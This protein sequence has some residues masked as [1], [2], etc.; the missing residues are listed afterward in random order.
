MSTDIVE[1]KKK[2][3]YVK[4]RLREIALETKQVM[5]GACKTMGGTPAM[6]KRHHCG[7]QQGC[8]E[9]GS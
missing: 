1:I 8:M 9:D 5:A 7:I 4:P 2:K 3:T 6:M